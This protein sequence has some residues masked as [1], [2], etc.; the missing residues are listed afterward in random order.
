MAVS[1]HLVNT[2]VGPSGVFSGKMCLFLHKLL[3]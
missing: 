2:A 1:V 3:M